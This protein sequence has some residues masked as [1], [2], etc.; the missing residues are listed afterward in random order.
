MLKYG[1]DCKSDCGNDYLSHCVE[2]TRC[3][4]KTGGFFTCPTSCQ[5]GGQHDTWWFGQQ[6]NL[7]LGK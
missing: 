1:Q 7:E 6:C 4:P 2:G 3:D 5:G